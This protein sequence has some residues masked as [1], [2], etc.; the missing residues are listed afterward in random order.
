MVCDLIENS[1]MRVSV[2]MLECRVCGRL[3]VEYGRQGPV[4]VYQPEKTPSDVGT[5]VRS[6]NEKE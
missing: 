3:L 2:R 1:I 4:A 6:V 5:F